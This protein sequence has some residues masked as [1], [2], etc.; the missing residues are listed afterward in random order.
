MNPRFE[1]GADCLNVTC[2]DRDDVAPKI[3]WMA[4]RGDCRWTGIN[5]VSHLGRSRRSRHRHRFAPSCKV[6]DL[7]FRSTENRRRNRLPVQIEW[8]DA[9]R[10][11]PRGRLR[12]RGRVA[13]R[14]LHQQ[15]P[16]VLPKMATRCSGGRSDYN[17]PIP[18]RGKERPRAKAHGSWGSPILSSLMKSHFRHCSYSVNF[19]GGNRML[20]SV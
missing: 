2:C 7:D 18:R 1:I 8:S 10:P 17:L 12:G 4:D 16:L 13:V 11:G 5:P 15:R 9:G 19:S 14:S 6:Q 20:F 3:L